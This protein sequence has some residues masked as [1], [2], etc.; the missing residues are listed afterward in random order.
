MA[1]IGKQ[2]S[3]GNFS[4][5]D[6]LTASSTASYT[7]QSGGTNFTPGSANQLIVSLNG[8]IQ[9]PGTSFT[10][11]G[12]TITFSSSLSSDDSIDFILAL[13]G[14]G[15]FNTP[16]DDS[17]TTAKIA[18]DAVT[19]A[20]IADDAITSA[21][22]ADDA[23]T[24]A[25]IDDNAVVTAAINGNAVTAAKFNADVISGQTELAAEPDDTDE[26]LVSDGGVI[27]RVD[28]SL[29]KPASFVGFKA[30][31]TSAQSISSQ[32]DTQVQFAGEIFDVG[33]NFASHSFTAPSD[34]KYLF[35]TIISVLALGD[36]TVDIKFSHTVS[37]GSTFT[38]STTRMGPMDTSARD[39]AVN[40]MT[41]M[42]M[43]QNST[44]HVRIFIF[45]A[46]TLGHNSTAGNSPTIF[47]GFKI[48]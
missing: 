16:S 7:M 33:G 46:K 25:L 12:S 10:V 44:V 15:N 27:K 29:I 39:G 4:V 14:V 23:I 19:S 31:A 42:D 47:G 17:I 6:D 13:G 22:I 30:V 32:T 5:L 11:N 48:G 36:S 20:K 9:E 2:P 21:L 24:S 26:F 38:G 8:V 43:T 41:T 18:T 37:G 28:Y 1:Y 3:A 34:G 45:A 35:Y 40:L